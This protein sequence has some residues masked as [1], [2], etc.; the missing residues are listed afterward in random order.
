MPSTSPTPN[1]TK[2]V[3]V[4][5]REFYDSF[6]EIVYFLRV[7]AGMTTEEIE[8]H[9]CWHDGI[10]AGETHPENG[11]ACL[12]RIDDSNEQV[13]KRLE[14]T[15]GVETSEILEVTE[16]DLQAELQ[17]EKAWASADAD[18]AA[19]TIPIVITSNGDLDANLPAIN[20]LGRRGAEEFVAALDDLGNPEQ[21]SR[22]EA[23]KLV[24]T[25]LREIVLEEP[26]RGEGVDIAGTAFDVTFKH[27]RTK[28][29]A[30]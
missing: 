12:G 10:D 16:G 17:A 8:C 23:A 6:G 20:R 3:R 14:T 13:I 28:Q 25:V 15:G 30:E 24:M 27:Y 2:I 19:A 4:T 5:R 7:P 11:V 26:A 29:E 22:D 1:E 21:L 9:S 18:R